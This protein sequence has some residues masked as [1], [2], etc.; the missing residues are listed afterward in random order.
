MLHAMRLGFNGDKGI[1][2]WQKILSHPLCWQ[3]ISSHGCTTSECMD[4]KG[5]RV[6][7]KGYC[8]D[9]RAIV[10]MLRAIVNL[11]ATRQAYIMYPVFR[12]GCSR[13]AKL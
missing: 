12:A 10:W 8:V 3:R 1:P 9:L 5:Y 6:D 13:R 11:A 7:V 2:P 4:V